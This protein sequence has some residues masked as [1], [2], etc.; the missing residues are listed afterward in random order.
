MDKLSKDATHIVSNPATIKKMKLMGLPIEER[1]ISYE[2]YFDKLIAQKRIVAVNLLSQLPLLDNS[3]AN[4]V[5]SEIYEEVRSS[6]GLSI[7]TS[8]IFNSIVL[9]EYSM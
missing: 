1:F 5:I 7:F 9:L 3:I 4:G 2:E 8:T 6:F